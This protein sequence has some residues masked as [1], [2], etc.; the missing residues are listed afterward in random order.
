MRAGAPDL[1]FAAETLIGQ[2]IQ[3]Y[4]AGRARQQS[5]WGPPMP[6]GARLARFRGLLVSVRTAPTR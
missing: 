1:R 6:L 3:L 4:G 5:G 2:P